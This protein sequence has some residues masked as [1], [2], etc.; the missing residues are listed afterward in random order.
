MMTNHLSAYSYNE[1]G[2]RGVAKKES[3]TKDRNLKFTIA[4]I[5]TETI[6]IY[7]DS[8]PI[9]VCQFSPTV[10]FFVYYLMHFS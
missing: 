4:I 9:A 8:M 7:Y 1:R 2:E 5:T 10:N 3:E 6:A